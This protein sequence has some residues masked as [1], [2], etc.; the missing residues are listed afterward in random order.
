MLVA[1]RFVI[2]TKEE[3]EGKIVYFNTSP[4]DSSLVG[5]TKR[6]ANIITK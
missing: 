5:M 6:L 2:P 1:S 3:S 4:S